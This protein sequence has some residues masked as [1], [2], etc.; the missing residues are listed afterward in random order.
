[1]VGESKYEQPSQRRKPML[2]M[3]V[4][5]S[6]RDP[7]PQQKYGTLLKEPNT[8]SEIRGP[9]IC[10]FSCLTMGGLGMRWARG[11][12]AGVSISS[13]SGSCCRR[14]RPS[15]SSSSRS[16]SSGGCSGR[17]TSGKRSNE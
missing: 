11:G 8:G 9:P 1:M 3:W 16:K 15:R 2:D 6:V 4:A 12:I 10:G 5:L 13:S 14:S 17:S 7:L